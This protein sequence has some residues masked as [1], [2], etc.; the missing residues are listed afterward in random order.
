M[1]A[2]RRSKRVRQDIRERHLFDE[3]DGR[4][5]ATDAEREVGRTCRRRDACESDDE[6]GDQADADTV[7][8]TPVARRLVSTPDVMSNRAFGVLG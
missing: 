3:V 5:P 1:R 2:R 4:R 6:E 8:A 7:R